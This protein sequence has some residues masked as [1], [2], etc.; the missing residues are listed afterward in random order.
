MTVHGTLVARRCSSIRALLRKCGTGARS[1]AATIHR[2]RPGDLR[3]AHTDGH[4]GLRLHQT[5]AVA[6]GDRA[7]VPR[8]L[9]RAPRRHQ[10]GRHGH[11][12]RRGADHGQRASPRAAH[13]RQDGQ[14]DPDLRAGVRQAA[15]KRPPHPLGP[16][17]RTAGQGPGLHPADPGTAGAARVRDRRPP[18]D[19]STCGGNSD[20]AP[21][22]ASPPQRRHI[23]RRADP[24]RP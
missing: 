9:P 23:L 20:R 14:P 18:R 24:G 10:L 3:P 11:Q 5:L 21:H 1:A 12:Q 7:P 15:S 8:Y 19:P 13:A 6:V 17:R 4:G 16:R 2:R 22:P